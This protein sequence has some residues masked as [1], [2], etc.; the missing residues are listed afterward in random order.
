M[1][2]QR[3]Q[4]PAIFRGELHNRLNAAGHPIASEKKM[5][6]LLTSAGLKIGSARRGELVKKGYY[7]ERIQEAAERLPVVE[8]L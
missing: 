8:V 1:G 3:W 5:V 7:V 2:G 4:H 6:Q